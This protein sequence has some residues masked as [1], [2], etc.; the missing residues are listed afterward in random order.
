[1]P[2]FY[3]FRT[4]DCDDTRVCPGREEVRAR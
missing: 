3:L 2:G 4:G 1:L